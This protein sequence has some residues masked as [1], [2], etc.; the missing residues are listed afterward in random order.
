MRNHSLLL[1]ELLS[2]R[3]PPGGR[4]WRERVEVI[5]GVHLAEGLIPTS[6]QTLPEFD[7]E[8]FLAELAGASRW[9][10]K[11]AIQL[12]M[13]ERGV[14]HKAGVTWD[15][16]G[17]PLDQLGRAAMLAVVS[18][19]LAPS[20]IE[21][22]LGDVHRQGE[23]R[24][25]QALLRALPFLVMPQRFV[26]L[27]VDACRSNERPVFE[28][29]ACENPYPAENFQEIQFNQL[30]LKALAFGIALERIIGLERRRS[31]ELMRMASDYAG[32]LRASGR[33]VPTDMNLLLD[34]S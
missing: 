2:R 16:D 14:L 19:R 12:T 26:A 21:R 24:E 7:H 3:I 18:S 29:I 1:L 13:A 6:F 27:A 9:L 25:R 10:G 28:A 23:T 5:T 34:A 11:E 17:W 33:T 22:L 32:E 31:V 8:G 4:R 20:E 30:V 15:I